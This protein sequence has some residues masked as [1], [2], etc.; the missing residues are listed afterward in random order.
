MI[1]I[2]SEPVANKKCKNTFFYL[3][4]MLFGKEYSLL[5]ET[6]KLSRVSVMDN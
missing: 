4:K 1:L 2:C 5:P 3:T 6:Q